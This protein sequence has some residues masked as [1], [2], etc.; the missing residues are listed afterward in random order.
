MSDNDTITDKAQRKAARAEKRE[1]RRKF[2]TQP[3][4]Q[5]RA[6]K[7]GEIW[8]QAMWLGT[9]QTGILDLNSDG[10]MK[11]TTV[12]GT[13]VTRERFNANDIESATIETAADYVERTSGGRVAGGALVG[14]VLLGPLGLALGAGA[15]ALAKQKH[16]GAEY[17]IIELNDGRTVTIEVARKHAIKAR[18]IRDEIT[19]TN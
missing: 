6:E 10:R 8:Y 2:W 7:R 19:R 17:L 14:G 3:L 11:Y 15:G 1:A 16:G 13:T 5:T 12:D 18:K 9:R 4:A